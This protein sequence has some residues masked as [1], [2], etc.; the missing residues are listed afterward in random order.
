MI[1]PYKDK[2]RVPR[3]YTCLLTGGSPPAS[4]VG[5]VSILCLISSR[6]SAEDLLPYLARILQIERIERRAVFQ[7]FS[8][9]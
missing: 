6:L 5:T 1:F 7:T 4:Y 2:S 8:F 3:I 9:K